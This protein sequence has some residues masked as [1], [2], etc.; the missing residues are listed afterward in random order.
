MD[1]IIY[2]FCRSPN[3]MSCYPTTLKTSDRH[4]PEA[5][6]VKANFLY[7]FLGGVSSCC[8]IN[9]AASSDFSITLFPLFS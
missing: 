1:K 3:K 6:A 2:F 9:E 8:Y 4:A 7:L 5:M